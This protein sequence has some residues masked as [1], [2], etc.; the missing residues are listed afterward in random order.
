MSAVPYLSGCYLVRERVPDGAPF[1]FDLACVKDLDL[2]LDAPVTFFVGE[3]GTG[4]STL[5]EA[6][7]EMCGFPAGGGGRDDGPDAPKSAS[8]QLARALRPRFKTRTRDGFFF[9]AEMLAGFADMLERRAADPD[10]WGDPYALYGDKSLHDRSHG[11]AFLEV[12]QARLGEGLFFFDEPEAALSP[13][14]Q[15]A[16]LTVLDDRVRAGG[17]QVLIATHSPIL[18]TY[19][20]ARILS[21]DRGAPRAVSVEETSHWKLTRAVLTDPARF[22]RSLRDEGA[23]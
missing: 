20:E 15:L 5:L 1:P 4:K 8:T 16:F 13:Q 10:F 12:I 7:A 17:C 9:R 6:I 22:W 3:N 21:F 14:R 11:E 2:T 23:T 18:M 19:P